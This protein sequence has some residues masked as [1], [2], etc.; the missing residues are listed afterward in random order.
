MLSRK[1]CLHIQQN[2]EYQTLVIFKKQMQ[3][4]HIFFKES[5]TS[6]LPSSVLT[7]TT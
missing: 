1:F 3:K 7:V 5:L 6:R 4:P 2:S